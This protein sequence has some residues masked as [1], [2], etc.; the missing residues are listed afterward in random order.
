[1]SITQWTNQIRFNVFLFILKIIILS[2][3]LHKSKHITNGSPIT[4]GNNSKN[5]R[6]NIQFKIL[7]LL[8]ENAYT[9]S[10]SKYKK[11]SS[12]TKEETDKLEY[13]G[14]KAEAIMSNITNHE[15]L[16]NKSVEVDLLDEEQLLREM[17]RIILQEKLIMEKFSKARNS[18]SNEYFSFY[19]NEE[20][21]INRIMDLSRK[22]R[23]YRNKYLRL[24][25]RILR[26]I[27]KFI[28]GMKPFFIKECKYHRNDL[29][30]FRASNF[31]YFVFPYVKCHI[32]IS[33]SRFFKQNLPNKSKY[34]NILPC[35]RNPK[36]NRK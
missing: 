31:Y 13:S 30:Q 29:E 22:S 33:F 3:F 15:D 24:W 7:R 28:K 2:F 27:N 25:Y 11:L 17:N 5:Q 8:N 32:K 35:L 12:I 36:G 9:D 6:N 21:C 16:D 10:A 26:H 18:S 20:N 14:K 23:L 1:M 34:L 19:F 4:P